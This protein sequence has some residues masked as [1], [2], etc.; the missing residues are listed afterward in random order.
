MPDLHEET[1]QES[2]RMVSTEDLKADSD[3]MEDEVTDEREDPLPEDLK[4]GWL[5]P[6]ISIIIIKGIIYP[7]K[8]S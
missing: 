5:S 1:F 8:L 6:K 2:Q 3:P 7:D 4:E